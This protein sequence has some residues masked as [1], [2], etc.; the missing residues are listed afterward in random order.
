MNRALAGI[1]IAVL[2]AAGGILAFGMTLPD[3]LHIERY[4]DSPAQLGHT[5]PLMSDLRTWPSWTAWSTELDP[6]VQW[7]FSGKAHQPGQTMRW[8]GPVMGDG[9][10]VLTAVTA[11]GVE[12]DLTFDDLEPSHGSLHHI[13]KELRWIDDIP[14]GD[15]PL[16]R[17]MG[18]KVELAVGEDFMKGLVA[19]SAMAVRCETSPTPEDKCPAMPLP[20]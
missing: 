4:M 19:M 9:Q 11:D 7:T 6:E 14:L 20:G 5:R 1:G 15:N 16:S 13:G 3:T 10:I 2:L 8:H 18:R 17:I 12:Y